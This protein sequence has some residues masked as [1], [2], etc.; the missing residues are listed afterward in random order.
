MGIF[1]DQ[2]EF[3]IDNFVSE[4]KGGARA[5]F[6]IWQPEFKNAEGKTISQGIS[7]DSNFN[8]QELKKRMYLVKA[9]NFPSTT[10]EEH[11][12]EYQGLNFK[13]GGKKIFEDWNITLYLDS[14]GKIRHELE[15][16]TNGIHEVRDGVN[17]QHYFENYK[18]TQTFLILDGSGNFQKP[19]LR[20]KLFGAWPKSIG[21]ISL[22]YSSSDFAEFELTFSYQYHIIDKPI[23]SPSKAFD[24]SSFLSSISNKIK[25][26][27]NINPTM[28]GTSTGDIGL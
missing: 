9:T 2:V 12:V 20:I 3:S 26:L 23:V 25:G 22:D 8:T 13:I 14:E 27:I 11:I 4:F 21:P 7:Y 1:T 18:S 17:I 5:S 24:L 15:E 16:W 19:L 28:S 10:V 6:F